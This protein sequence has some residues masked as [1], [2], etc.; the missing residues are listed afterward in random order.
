MFVIATTID[1]GSIFTRQ[2]QVLLVISEYSSGSLFLLFWTSAYTSIVTY[3]SVSRALL[4]PLQINSWLEVSG[5]SKLPVQSLLIFTFSKSFSLVMLTVKLRGKTELAIRQFHRN[6]KQ[7][8]VVSNWFPHDI[9]LFFIACA[10]LN[11]S[12]HFVLLFVSVRVANM[13]FSMSLVY[14]WLILWII[15]SGFTIN[16]I[17]HFTQTF[18]VLVSKFPSVFEMDNIWYSQSKLKYPKDD[19]LLHQRFYCAKIRKG[20]I[21]YD[22]LDA[23]K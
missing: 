9:A 14:C 11:P 18:Y 15:V 23:L 6:T 2:C 10:R 3:V 5:F 4:L 22:N 17:P 7:P 12:D 16:Y 21:L 19:M 13:L 20:Q 8:S 1:F